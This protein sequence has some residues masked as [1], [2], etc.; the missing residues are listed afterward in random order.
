MPFWFAFGDSVTGII[1][2]TGTYNFSLSKVSGPGDIQGN[3]GTTTG[4]YSYLDNISFSDFG[5]YEVDVNVSGYPG[6]F[7]G[8][9]KFIVPPEKDF[10]DVSNFGGCDSAGGN[11][12]LAIPEFSNVVPV[13]EV[14]PIMV[15]LVDSNT[16]LLDST[17]TGTIEVDKLSG[18]GELYGILSMTG[19]PWFNFNYLQFNEEGLYT[20]RFFEENIGQYK[21]GLLDLEVIETANGLMIFP[22]SE[23]EVYPNPF[24]DEIVITS[25]KGLNG[26]RVIFSNS[27]G[28]KVFENNI[29]NSINKI[30]I[31]TRELNLG[32][33]FVTV[34]D[35]QF[36]KITTYKLVK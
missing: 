23:L 29:S 19:G 14:M 20:I 33:Y 10:C 8:K 18:P 12:I 27:L 7:V 35:S 32:V 34:I 15:G 30:K 26:I 11:Q 6:S 2:T 3:S 36:S 9:L 24:D 28:Q 16:G 4:Y 22:F 31:D 21:D 25:K 13:D 1:D 5:N 17:F